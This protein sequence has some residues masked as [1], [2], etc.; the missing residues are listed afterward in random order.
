[1]AHASLV[2]VRLFLEGE[3]ASLMFGMDKTRR[4]FV[5]IQNIQPPLLR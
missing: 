1:M 5:N 2:L 3:M 4:E